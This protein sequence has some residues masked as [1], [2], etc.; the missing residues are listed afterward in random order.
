MNQVSEAITILLGVMVIAAVGFEINRRQ[1][2]LREV[3]DVLDHESRHIASQLEEMVQQG[4]LQ[5]Y[6]GDALV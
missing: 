3:Y 4:A 5:P 6:R 1:R 2:Q